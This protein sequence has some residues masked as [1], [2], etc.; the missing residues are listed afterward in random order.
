MTDR[1][2]VKIVESFWREVWQAKDPQAAARFVAEDFVIT[3][4]GVDIV[5]REA[6]I[7]W[8]GAF[9]S[10]IEDFEFGAIETFQNAQGTRVASRWKLTG[11]NQ[12]FIGGRTCNSPFEMLGTA[13]WEVRPD[14]LLAH[15]WVERNALEVH[16]DMI[17]LG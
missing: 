3:S 7:R 15:N 4:G 17:G 13:V 12:G 5:G 9:L 10:T 16:R 2:A 6:F 11:K 14:G 1:T 8:I